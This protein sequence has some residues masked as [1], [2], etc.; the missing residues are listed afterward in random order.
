M[1]GPLRSG[2][3]D[4]TIA[5]RMPDVVMRADPL[6]GRTMAPHESCHQS[7]FSL[8]LLKSTTIT[9]GLSPGTRVLNTHPPTL[10]LG[11]ARMI[12]AL[13]KRLCHWKKETS[14]QPKG[15]DAG[16]CQW[17]IP[18]N[19]PGSSSRPHRSPLRG[20]LSRQHSPVELSSSHHLI[21]EPFR[22]S[23]EPQ[24]VYRVNPRRRLCS[25]RHTVAFP[26]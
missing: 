11:L 20:L 8:C 15:E 17:P 18:N 16:G 3:D 2:W 26:P 12:W 22:L 25:P 14:C 24:R 10:P 6:L 21:I 4:T 13:D 9:T 7:L 23:R 5:S 19:P 1:P